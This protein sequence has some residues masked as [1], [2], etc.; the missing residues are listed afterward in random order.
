MVPHRALHT[1]LTLL[2]AGGL[3]LA[4][5]LAGFWLL[6]TYEFRPGA[7]AEPPQTWPGDAELERAAD[8]DTLL[9]FFHPQCPCS[10]ATVG[11]LDR[12]AARCRDRLKLVACF[13][14]E[15]GTE[16]TW[17]RR[18]LWSQ[19]TAIPGVVA[20]VDHTGGIARRFGA[21]T[22]GQVL[23]YG[24]DGRLRF[25]GGITASRGHAGDNAGESSVLSLV[26]EPSA[27][28][29]AAPVFGCKLCRTPNP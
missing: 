6:S 22:S 24:A 7:A 14:C 5:V 4:G 28:C 13:V 16:D 1:R 18:E 8:K 15:S 9:V 23:L 2:L 21:H 3:W 12:I 20:I 26:L 10:R 29:A 11:E 19:V 25:S 17:V 27:E